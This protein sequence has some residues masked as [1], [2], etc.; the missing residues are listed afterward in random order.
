MRNL[1]LN[2]QLNIHI[3]VYRLFLNRLD[4]VLG[5]AF[6]YR[7]AIHSPYI[8]D[9]SRDTSSYAKTAS[10]DPTERKMNLDIAHLPRRTPFSLRILTLIIG[11][12]SR[13]VSYWLETSFYPSMFI[14]HIPMYFSEHS[15]SI[16]LI[17]WSFADLS[18]FASISQQ[19][20]GWF[21]QLS[22]GGRYQWS[23]PDR[24]DDEPVSYTHLTLPTKRIV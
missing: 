24:S 23:T 19:R 12:S 18:S 20:P 1:V 4:Q 6:D 7:S 17:P 15:R 21:G 10:L 14:R 2:Q 9:C 3:S 22:Q 11:K 16:S 5:K 13:S 8:V